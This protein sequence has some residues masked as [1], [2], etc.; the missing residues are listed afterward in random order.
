MLK[1]D[2]KKAYLACGRTDMRKSINGL[3]AIVE[4][5]F[6]LDP[7]SEAIFVFCNRNRDRIKILEWDC[8]GFW[9]YF[10]RLEKGRF[11]WPTEGSEATMTLTP[12]ELQILLGGAKVELKL[13]R[14]EVSER[15]VI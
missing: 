9:L 11:R 3:A 4:S 6:H 13:K 12:E 1:I 2:G 15:W 14:K 5:S 7:F 10:K 8:D